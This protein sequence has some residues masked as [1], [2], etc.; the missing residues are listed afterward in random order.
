MSGAI[1]VSDL[2]LESFGEPLNVAVIGSSG[3]IGGAL[4]HA[5]SGCA[6]VD[7][8]YALSRDGA[9]PSDNRVIGLRLDV[10]DEG[11]IES[12]A[13]RIREDGISLNLVIV[14]SGIL[15]DSGLSPEKTWRAVTRDSMETT[16]QVNTVGPAL[17][18]KHFLPLLASD[19]KAAFAALSARVGS[20]EDNRLGGW[21]SYRASKAALNMMVKTLSVELARRQPNAICVALHP[22]TVDTD[23]SR[24]F[25]SSVPQG[26]LF[27]P[28]QAAR[29][30]LQTLDG[31]GTGDSGHHFA[32]DGT[33]IRA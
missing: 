15:H 10:L 28:A 8:L 16:F 7:R 33:R 1:K 29:N 21:H 24:P 31:L 17:V 27:T 23:L 9:E 20:I 25:Q 30:L 4:V 13:A 2:G 11:A 26:N 32:W 5:L 22:G 19:G 14:A 6:G 3:G 18:A 12:A